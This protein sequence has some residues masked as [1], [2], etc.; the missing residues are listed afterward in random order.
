MHKIRKYSYSEVVWG[1]EIISG[2]N[3]YEVPLETL[4]I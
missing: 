4:S 3:L 1:K 2:T